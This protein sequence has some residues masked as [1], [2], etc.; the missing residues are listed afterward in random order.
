MALF[1]D[2][3]KITKNRSVLHHFV[4]K[5]KI[6]R[7]KYTSSR[8][9]CLK[10][11]IGSRKKDKENRRAKKKPFVRLPPSEWHCFIMYILIF[12]SNPRH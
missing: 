8:P 6:H 9:K 12:P 4:F 2:A 3:Q 1:T 11:F 7:D 5:E 10:S